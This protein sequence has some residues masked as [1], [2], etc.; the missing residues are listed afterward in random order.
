ML[1][2][3]PHGRLECNVLRWRG[4]DVNRAG[5]DDDVRRSCAAAENVWGS[6]NVK[7]HTLS[8]GGE[9]EE[10]RLWHRASK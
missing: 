9:P 5:G 3:P 10:R 1:G 2:S 7:N 4:S 6:R 8:G